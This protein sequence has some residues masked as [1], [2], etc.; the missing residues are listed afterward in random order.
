MPSSDS[1][2][3]SAIIFDCFGVLAGGSLPALL[4]LAPPDRRVDV[5]DVNKQVDYGMI[6]QS[7]YFV[8]LAEIIGKTPAEIEQFLRQKHFLNVELIDYAKQLKQH[9]KIGLLSNVGRGGLDG[10]FTEQEIEQLFDTA[11]LSFEETMAK[12]HPYIFNLAADRLQAPVSECIM[13]DDFPS[14]CDG[15]RAAGMTAIL[16]T[17]N[18][19]TKQQVDSLLGRNS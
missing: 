17:S 16:H 6:D 5:T 3:I 9:Y 15:A 14:N 13:I 12:P 1:N 2:Q 7:E 4:G 11:V 8:R 19:S 10:V 18:E